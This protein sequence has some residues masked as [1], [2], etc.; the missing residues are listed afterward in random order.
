MSEVSHFQSML[1]KAAVLKQQGN[2]LFKSRDYDLARIKYQEA[3]RILE[4]N[5]FYG[6]TEK[7]CQVLADLSASLLFNVGTCF[8]NQQ[9]WKNA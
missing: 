9:K 4:P 7:E 5:S 2:E 1:D 8:F 6:A 3:L